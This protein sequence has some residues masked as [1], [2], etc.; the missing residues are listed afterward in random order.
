M[1]SLLAANMVLEEKNV[2]LHQLTQVRNAGSELVNT[3]IGTNPSDDDGLLLILGALARDNKDDIQRLIVDELLRRSNAVQASVTGTEEVITLNYALGNTGSELALDV[4]LESLTHGEIDVQV[5]AVRS[6]EA[7]VCQPV[8][9]QGLINLLHATTEDKV[10]EEVVSLL[11]E[12]FDNQA[13]TVVS[14]ELLNVTVETAIELQN[15]HLYEFLIK[16]LKRLGTSE[17]DIH[18]ATIKQ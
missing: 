13:C 17:A 1:A 8:T 10:L 4:I 12:A 16:Y 15:P 7:H 3:V 2:L 6:L 11:I 5:S 9:Q 14:D 18:I